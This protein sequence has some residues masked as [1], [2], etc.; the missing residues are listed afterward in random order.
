MPEIS[1]L[2][3]ALHVGS[4]MSLGPELPPFK[5][6]RFQ[7]LETCLQETSHLPSQ[8]ITPPR[9]LPFYDEFHKLIETFGSQNNWLHFLLYRMPRKMA[10][11]ILI[12]FTRDSHQ[13]VTF[14][15]VVGLVAPILKNNIHRTLTS[16]SKD[17]SNQK[18]PR[19]CYAAMSHSDHI[20]HKS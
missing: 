7:G 6:F 3:L 17:S 1:L 11:V 10:T 2:R 9:S 19:Q 4:Y 20:P 12:Y 15:V 5:L 14:I 16:I 18:A 13:P 8:D